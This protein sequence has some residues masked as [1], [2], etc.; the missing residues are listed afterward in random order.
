MEL[1]ENRWRTAGMRSLRLFKG[2]GNRFLGGEDAR[3][4]KGK[5]GIYVEE[6]QE[7]TGKELPVSGRKEAGG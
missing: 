4:R 2:C 3:A 5:H 6:G 1:D 7:W